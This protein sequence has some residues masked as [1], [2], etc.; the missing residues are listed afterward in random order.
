MLFFYCGRRK[1]WTIIARWPSFL[2]LPIFSIYSFSGE[3]IGRKWYLTVSSRWSWINLFISAIGICC[4]IHFLSS[5]ETRSS[6]NLLDC[7]WFA[8]MIISV[9]LIILTF[10]F[11]SL[12]TIPI[13]C[14]SSCIQTPFL[15]KTALDID[16][17][18]VFNLEDLLRAETDP[19]L[20]FN[21]IPNTEWYL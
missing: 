7:D 1:I 8:A 9:P 5:F 4:G 15:Q 20:E 17:L 13:T 16:T 3:K 21:L 12:L 11:H 14:P 6:Y 19:D 18:E 10:I 2:L